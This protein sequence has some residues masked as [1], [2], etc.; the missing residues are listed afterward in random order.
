MI[1]KG[2][3]TRFGGLGVN[4][5]K[6]SLSRQGREGWEISAGWTEEQS[7]DGSPRRAPEKGTNW[8]HQ[9]PLKRRVREEVKSLSRDESTISSSLGAPLATHSPESGDVVSKEAKPEMN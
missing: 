8:R 4:W 5:V 7:R 6:V 1:A 3:T 9:V 2:V